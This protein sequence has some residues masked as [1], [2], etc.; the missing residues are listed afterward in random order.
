MS[1]KV[2]VPDIGNF[3]DVPV[4]EVLVKAGDAIRPEDPLIL[5]ESDKAMMEVPSPVGGVVGEL[6]LKAGDTV[7]KGTPILTVAGEAATEQAAGADAPKPPAEPSTAVAAA[8]PSQPAKATPP[9][10]PQS[11][12]P[13]APQIPAHAAT[14][15]YASPSVRRLAREK[16]IDLARVT[17]SGA[18]GRILAGDLAAPASAGSA[19]PFDIPPWPEVEPGAHGPSR[20]EPLSRIG[21]LSGP[22]LHRNWLH[23]P[24]VTCFD[25]AD[26]SG[27]E[28]FRKEVNAGDGPKLSLLVLV[29]KA[30]AT[31][32]REHPR[33]N[34]SLKGGDLLLHDYVHLGVAVDTPDGL[35][36]PVVRDCDRL[37]VR[38]IAAEL[39]RLVEKARKGRLQPAEMQGG[40]F[41]LSS[42]GG[43]GGDHFTPIVN[44]PEVA[45]LGLG[46]AAW[47]QVSDDGLE[48]NA[49][50]MLPLSLSFDH[51]A[52]DGAAAARFNR[53]LAACLAD[54]RRTLL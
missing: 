36:V 32:L 22:G 38:A 12:D 24:H 41:T 5:I 10:S 11:A 14:E 47:R 31:T 54:V 26:V 49:R 34:A 44:A 15:P 40:T 17:G 19:L 42:L 29:M 30:V 7:S 20:S 25:E 2:C 33:L 16:G 4:V 21:R 3:H 1:E 9:A 28:A 51:R 39:E 13:A 8:T 45:I 37:D 27:L 43:I 18:F 48:W 46:R 23:I 50:L 35:Y 52:L 6:L 53:A